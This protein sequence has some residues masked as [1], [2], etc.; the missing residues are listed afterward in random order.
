MSLV[1]T[2]C[3]RTLEYSGDRPSFCAY[4]GQRLSD[5]SLDETTPYDSK[6]NPARSGD[7]LGETVAHVAERPAVVPMPQRVGSYRL[8]RRLGSGG[9]GTVYEAVDERSGH[10]VALK[11]ISPEFVASKD[12]LDRFCQEGRLASML[13]HPRC[14][15]VL[16]ADQDEQGRPYIVME[17]MPGATLQALVETHGRLPV[18]DA[19]AKILDVIDGLQEAHQLGVVHRDVKPANCF[20][21][22][23]GRVK[24]GDFGL[25]KSLTQDS[26]LTPLRRIHRHP[27]VCVPRADQGEA[28]R[29]ANRRLLRRRDALL[30]TGRPATVQVERCGRHA[31]PDCLGGSPLHSRFPT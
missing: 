3:S 30:R 1:C 5:P 25:S 21:D 15:F 4:C 12:A 31:R 24:V 19:I 28:G 2:R 27:L 18:A 13:E 23:D 17:L 14:V 16:T 11:L 9:M 20:L 8:I 7:D 10:R 26:G 22:G 29:C 6:P